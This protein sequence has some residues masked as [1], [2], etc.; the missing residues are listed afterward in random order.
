MRQNR[1]S[2]FTIKMYVAV[3]AE[4]HSTIE[5][6]SYGYHI[7]LKHL[8]ARS[9]VSVGLDSGAELNAEEYKLASQETLL[10]AR[11]PRTWP[12]YALMQKK[13]N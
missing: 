9:S 12:L 8:S 4:N 7:P 1:K 2:P 3:N 6:M 13:N 10:N 5:G 11:A